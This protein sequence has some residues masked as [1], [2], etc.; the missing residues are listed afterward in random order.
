[1]NSCFDAQFGMRGALQRLS[2]GCQLRWCRTAGGVG[3]RSTIGLYRHVPL[4]QARS[5]LAPRAYTSAKRKTTMEHGGGGTSPQSTRALVLLLGSAQTLSWASSYYLPAV[6][7][8]AMAADL[9]VAPPTV[10]AAFSGALAVT[11]LWG[12]K[13]G[14][15]IDQRGGRQVLVGSH[16]LFALG[17]A[18][19]AWAPSV[20]W[21]WAAWLWMG[22]GMALGLYEG[23]FAAIVRIQGR[24]ATSAITGVT[25]M[26]GFA[27]TVGWPLST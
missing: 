26:A 22:L 2:L 25:L 21:L 8:P 27:S 16:I 12:P 10:F 6:L 1:M 20:A 14:R 9:G 5:D 19:L 3:H 17:L 18:A 24:G 4:P 13:A 7:A 23:A 15:W 11:A